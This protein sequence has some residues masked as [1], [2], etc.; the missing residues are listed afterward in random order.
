M[1]RAGST[2]DFTYQAGASLKAPKPVTLQRV[3]HSVRERVNQRKS[4]FVQCPRNGLK[5]YPPLLRRN[6]MRVKFTLGR[7][8]LEAIH[9]SLN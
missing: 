6:I 3:R 4:Q 8:P 5:P 9:A 2:I 7:L 1:A